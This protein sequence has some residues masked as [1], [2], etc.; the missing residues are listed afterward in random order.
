MFVVLL[1][2]AG[3]VVTFISS[4]DRTQTIAMVISGESQDCFCV[5]EEAKTLLHAQRL[6]EMKA[7]VEWNKV[8]HDDDV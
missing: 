2:V 7:I 1:V 4:Q 5:E 8:S 6:Q 3:L